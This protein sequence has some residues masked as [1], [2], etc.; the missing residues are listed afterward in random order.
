[1]KNT[2]RSTKP[3]HSYLWY[4]TFVLILLFI[5][6]SVLGRQAIAQ[7]APAEAE[8]NRPSYAIEGEVQN[9]GHFPLA[10]NFR[11][12]NAIRA[13]G[14]LTKDADGK[15]A[16]IIR[17]NK[18]QKAYY[19]I[20]FQADSALSGDPTDNFVLLDKDRIIIH[21]VR[22]KVD[23]PRAV[24]KAEP[25]KAR[26]ENVFIAGEIAKPGAYPYKEDMTVWDLV[27]KSGGTLKTSYPEQAEILSSPSG[28]GKPSGTDRKIINLKKAMEDD[29]AHN[30]PLHLNDRLVVKSSPD[31][32]KP[33]PTVCLSGEVQLP[34]KYSITKEERLFSVI[35]RAGGFASSAYLRAA[36]FTKERVRKLQQSSLEELAARLEGDLPAKNT[37]PESKG[38]LLRQIKTLKATGRIKVG[39]TG[40][41][42]QM[43][44]ARDIELEDGD[45]LY[46]PSLSDTVRV[47]GAV[48]S[49]GSY[50]HNGQSDYRDYIEAAGGYTPTADESAA[51]VIKVDGSTQKVAK[52]F[53]DWS[54]KRKRL[55]IGGSRY[56][57]QIIEPGDVIV[58]PER[59]VRPAWLR[60]IRDITQALMNNGIVA[61]SEIKK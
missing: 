22:E 15:R 13:S 60:E 16:E 36:V 7:Q 9:A 47:A 57:K 29:P 24:A 17:Y 3:I 50:D 14:G 61:P 5:M 48:K 52:E 54:S 12:K 30:L 21:S 41:D 32:G 20:Y 34:G 10:K 31:G 45:S 11:V 35:E 39:V 26:Q 43:E 28:V 33:L 55:E 27:L 18:R 37:D 49:E 1:L 25:Q 4:L 19:T 8:N 2:A 53:F 58:V 40:A 51:L 56:A 42:M 46:V 6:I 23:K 44:R 38:N 59:I